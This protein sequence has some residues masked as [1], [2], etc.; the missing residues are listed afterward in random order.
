MSEEKELTGYPSID[1]P[2]LKH[3]SE[4][5]L[6]M[7]IPIC[8]LYD[9]LYSNNKD[10]LSGYAINYFGTKITYGELFKKDKQQ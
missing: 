1:K 8:S 6:N 5:E 9:Y 7:D 4:Q 10:N 2:W 3:Y